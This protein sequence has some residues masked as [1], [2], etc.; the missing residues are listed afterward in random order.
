VAQPKELNSSPS[1]SIGG[2]AY[3]MV[4]QVAGYKTTTKVILSFLSFS[5]LF[6]N[7]PVLGAI[8]FRN[9]T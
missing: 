1:P 2:V 6:K 9:L 5:D 3:Q 4:H 8:P 7:D